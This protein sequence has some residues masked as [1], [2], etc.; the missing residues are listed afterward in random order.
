MNLSLQEKA[1]AKMHISDLTSQS[2]SNLLK[3]IFPELKVFYLNQH[4][5]Q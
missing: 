2:E 3:S 5:C 4:F 1:W